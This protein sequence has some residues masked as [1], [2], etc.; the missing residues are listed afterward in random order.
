[1][2]SSRIRLDKLDPN[3]PLAVKI[4]EALVAEYDQQ[5]GLVSAG[6]QAALHFKHT[7]VES[8]KAVVLTPGNQLDH[9]VAKCPVPTK[10]SVKMG[11]QCGKSLMVLS[12]LLQQKYDSNEEYE[13]H[14]WCNDA[15]K[16]GLLSTVLY[17]P[18]PFVLSTK[19]E[20]DKEVKLKTKTKVVKAFLMHPHEYTPDFMLEITT[21][22]ERFLYDRRLT[23]RGCLSNYPGPS[24][25][26][27]VDVKGGFSLYHDDKPFSIN[28]KWVYAEH[29]V[30]MH[31]VVPK[32][33]FAKTWV[34]E[35]AL[36]SPKLH[37]L[38]DCYRGCETFKTIK[39][40]LNVQ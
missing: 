13:F 9:W 3:N 10:L 6:V 12:N 28:Q 36:Y 7:G 32:K 19:V 18:H 4:K 24:L 35:A 5:K 15:L 23:S 37:K 2:K 30:Y 14:A 34:P 11:R 16:L 29:Q 40:K 26:M 1:M 31:K 33:W 22:G 20:I 27:Y 21:A 17:H 25:R 8:C 38:K 39:E